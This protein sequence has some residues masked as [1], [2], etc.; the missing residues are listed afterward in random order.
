MSS[1][2]TNCMNQSLPETANIFFDKNKIKSRSGNGSFNN[3]VDQIPTNFDHL[4]P[5][6]RQLWTFYMLKV[7]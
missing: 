7:S 5:S 1:S 4:V 3:Y 6:S 2:L